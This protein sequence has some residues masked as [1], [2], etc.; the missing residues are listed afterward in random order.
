MHGSAADIVTILDS[1]K[2]E[3]SPS[4]R[5]REGKQLLK[6][7][8]KSFLPAAD[9]IMDMIRIHL[10]SPAT[11]QKYRTELL[12]DGSMETDAAIGVVKCSATSPLVIYISKMIPTSTPGTFYA[13]GRVFSG[14]AISGLPV[15][16]Q[17]P[18]GTPSGW[19][20]RFRSTISQLF[21]NV[22]T[23]FKR[24]NEVPAGNLIALSG[25]DQYLL[26]YGLIATGD[27]GLAAKAARRTAPMTLQ[28]SVQTANAQD[29]PKLV[30]GFK[31]LSKFDNDVQTSVSD[32]GEYI[33]AGRGELHLEICLQY[34]KKQCS[35]AT[36]VVSGPTIQYQET[37]Q[38]ASSRVALSKSPNKHS[39]LYMTAEPMGEELLDAI[40]NGVVSVSADHK[41]RASHLAN[42]FNWDITDGQKLWAFSPAYVGANL[43]VDQTKQVQ[44]LYEIR[45]S[46]VAG[47][48]WATRAGPIAEEPIRSVRFNLMDV[49]LNSDAIH[50]GAGQIMPTSRRVLYASMLLANPALLEPV[51][52]AD[53]Q[54]PRE[55][56]S[57]VRKTLS[58]RR[59]CI[60]SEQEHFLEN[61]FNINAS[62]PAMETL[63]IRE[64]LASNLSFAQLAFSGWQICPGSPLDAGTTAGKVV[65]AIR[66]RKG[67]KGDIP[68]V[69]MVRI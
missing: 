54:V 12:Y 52:T 27:I 34:L 31:C 58:R 26:R 6:V 19:T 22:G 9:A 64:E 37:V 60:L 18:D 40:E 2:I 46:V 17:C 20:D 8:M 24:V 50:R 57:A 30:E 47:F 61:I 28:Y 38:Q 35:E 33:I 48:Q 59:G 21:L 3:L 41:V 13:F 62:L 32:S 11:A 67:I 36:L 16:I 53:F 23:E 29:L 68:I 39:R 4:D 15:E 63:G 14:T 25:F 49:M 69:D 1:L 10:P 5:S 56:I 44:Y 7:V 45:D 55:A 51:Y 66:K 65:A 43:L 42:E